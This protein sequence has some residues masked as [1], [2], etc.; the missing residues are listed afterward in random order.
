MGIRWFLQRYHI[1]TDALIKWL[2]DEATAAENR[3]PILLLSES[4]RNSVAVEKYRNIEGHSI[5]PAPVIMTIA[6]PATGPD[7][8]PMSKTK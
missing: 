3:M 7:R 4:L 5:D 1:E 8:I 2:A 6:P